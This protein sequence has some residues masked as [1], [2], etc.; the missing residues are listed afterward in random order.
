MFSLILRVLFYILP[1]F[2]HYILSSFFILHFLLT[3]F[4]FYHL[5]AIVFIRAWLSFR[6]IY[7]KTV[8]FAI[9]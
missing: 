4:C 9:F 5:N 1:L 7:S 6:I 8:F 2:F 3:S